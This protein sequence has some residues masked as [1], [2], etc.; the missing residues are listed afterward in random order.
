MNIKPIVALT[1]DA[2]KDVE[3]MAKLNAVAP[4]YHK[5]STTVARDILMEKLNEIVSNLGIAVDYSGART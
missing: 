1:F 2:R 4:Y 5:K 3:L